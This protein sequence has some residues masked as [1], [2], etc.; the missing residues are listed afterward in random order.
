MTATVPG[1]VPVGSANVVVK[2]A[3]I[4]PVPEY[5]NVVVI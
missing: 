5:C 3:V 1:V 4:V 2:A